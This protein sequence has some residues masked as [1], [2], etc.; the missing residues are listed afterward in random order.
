V[1]LERTKEVEGVHDN[2][3]LSKQVEHVVVDEIVN[4]DELVKDANRISLKEK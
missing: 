4:D 3:P 2:T 1:F